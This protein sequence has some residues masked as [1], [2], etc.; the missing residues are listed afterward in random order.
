MVMK[1]TKSD[2]WINGIQLR[3][4][5]FYSFSWNIK[6]IGVLFCFSISKKYLSF[7]LFKLH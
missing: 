4:K 6:T 2:H 3:G 7:D 5:D 1:T